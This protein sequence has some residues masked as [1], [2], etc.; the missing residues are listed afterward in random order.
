MYKTIYYASLL[1]IVNEIE[2]EQMRKEARRRK[3]GDA[4]IDV[5]GTSVELDPE[6]NYE[7]LVESEERRMNRYHGLRVV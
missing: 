4:A 2:A 6:V 5:E 3:Y 1:E 7:E